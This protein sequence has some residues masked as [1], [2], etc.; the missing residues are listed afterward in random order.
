LGADFIEKAEP[1][2]ERDWDDKLTRLIDPTLFPTD[3]KKKPRTYQLR[4]LG[5]HTF[6]EGEYLTLHQEPDGV[7]AYRG[8][9][10]ELVGELVAPPRAL[11]RA[12]EAA[13]GTALAL[14][15]RVMPISG[16]AEVSL[17]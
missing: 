17:S 6:Q 5:G 13:A 7:R 16:F 14:V 4:P 2:L 1:T 12:L 9:E 3:K 11:V 15:E 8:V 10:Q